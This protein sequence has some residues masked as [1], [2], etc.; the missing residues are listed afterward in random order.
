MK[1]TPGVPVEF[2]ILV[3][4]CLTL[5]QRSK[6]LRWV[7]SIPHCFFLNWQLRERN[8]K[9]LMVRRILKTI[10]YCLWSLLYQYFRQSLDYCIW[11]LEHD[12]TCSLHDFC[13]ILSLFQN[14]HYRKPWSYRLDVRS[15][16]VLYI[17]QLFI[18]SSLNWSYY[19]I[20]SSHD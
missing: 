17:K 3:I 4:S 9:H 8:F 19:S 16:Q 6:T 20:H 18:H 1:L 12:Q 13:I 7:L 10:G 15:P 2:K 14:L 5:N 11:H